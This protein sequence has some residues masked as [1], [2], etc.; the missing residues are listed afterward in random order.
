VKLIRKGAAFNPGGPIELLGK[1]GPSEPPALV[2]D[3]GGP[4]TTTENQAVAINGTITDG[5][6]TLASSLWTSSPATGSFTSATSIDTT[7]TPTAPG[8]YVLTLTA[9]PVAGSPVSDTAGLT[10]NPGYVAPV[11]SA[12]GPYSGTAG[13]A[14]VLDGTV[15]PGSDPNPVTLWSIQSGG[16]GTFGDAAAI[17][18]TFTPDSEGAYVI[19]L[20]A[21]PNDGTPVT[22]N[23]NVTSAFTPALLSPVAWYDPSD[24]TTLFQD[25]AGTIPATANGD[26]VARMNDKSGNGRH[27]TQSSASRLPLLQISGGKTYIRGDGV[28]DF[29]IS[30]SIDL[31]AANV[32]TGVAGYT[33]RNTTGPSEIFGFVGQATTVNGAAE[34]QTPNNGT[35]E[36]I[37]FRQN[38]QYYGADYPLP[39][40]NV[41]YVSQVQMNLVAATQADAATLWRNNVIVTSTGG[42]GFSS[43]GTFGNGALSLLARTDG[44]NQSNGDI[45]GFLLFGRALTATERNSLY[46]WMAAKL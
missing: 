20:L 11:V 6:S 12:G 36:T 33:M 22:S 45:Y 13:T 27:L 28:D 32:L 18:T 16:T 4:Y 42:A 19:R 15:T 9:T 2:V 21:D 38:A 1:S 3:A 37:R 29:L 41:P 31:T 7:F 39:T 40:Q 23:A 46:T 34:Q 5:T 14:I 25:E 30:A 17:D 8:G 44:G 10:A 26:L 35:R 43:G 24:L